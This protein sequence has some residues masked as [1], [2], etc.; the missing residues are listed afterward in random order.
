[1]SLVPAVPRRSDWLVGQLPVG[2]LDDSLFYRFA[3]IFQEEAA[4]YLDGLDNLEHVVDPALAPP[5][6]VRFLA[7]WLALPSLDASLDDLYQ[8]RLVK[9][10]A[11]LRWWRGT[12]RGLMG[13]LELLTGGAVEVVDNGGIFGQGGALECSPRVR[14]RVESSGWLSD[15]D[16]LEVVRDEVPANASLELF[17]GER[18]LWPSQGTPEGWERCP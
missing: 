3:S 2:M 11:E 16:L 18:Q 4:S 5:G 8:R 14:V 6:M 12:R 1:M 13:L 10:A 7:S 9:A 17:V 15:A